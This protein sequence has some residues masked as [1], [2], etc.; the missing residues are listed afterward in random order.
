[1]GFSLDAYLSN[2]FNFLEMKDY[3]K[4]LKIVMREAPMSYAI[5]ACMDYRSEKK[6]AKQILAKWRKDKLN[7]KTN[8]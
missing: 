3:P 6:T 4:S 5:I 2:P 7:F 1:M 8:A